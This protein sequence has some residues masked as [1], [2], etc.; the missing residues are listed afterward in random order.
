MRVLKASLILKA[1]VSKDAV[2]S[3]HN[4]RL[5]SELSFQIGVSVLKGICLE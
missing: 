2:V 5:C 1:A 4:I 3:V